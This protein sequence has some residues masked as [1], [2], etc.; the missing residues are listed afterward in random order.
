M[1]DGKMRMNGKQDRDDQDLVREGIR[2]AV[3]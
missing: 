2:A 1:K 3:L